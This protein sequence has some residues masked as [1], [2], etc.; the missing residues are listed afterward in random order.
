[1]NKYPQNLKEMIISAIPNCAMMVLGMLTLNLC[2]YGHLSW[3]NFLAAVGPIYITAFALD[4]LLVG[5]I[6]RRIVAKYNI[7]KYMPFIRV[8][9]M[10]GI[11]T[12]LAPVIETGIAP[13][14]MRYL[15][16]LPR[17]Y[18]AALVLQVFV[19]MPLGL[20]VLGVWREIHKQNVN[21]A[22]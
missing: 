7:Y 14:I 9:F 18:V 5:P 21:V 22:K 6:V 19:A 13:G 4:F 10:A 1:M 11:L 12:G 15:M 16:A 20:Y 17:N 2:I 8:G 3:E